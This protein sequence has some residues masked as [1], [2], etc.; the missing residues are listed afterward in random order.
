MDLFILLATVLIKGIG[1]LLFMA[2]PW[3]AWRKGFPVRALVL[4]TIA[5]SVVVLLW[6]P[7]SGAEGAAQMVGQMWWLSV[8]F[9]VC[10]P[11]GMWAHYR[12]EKQINN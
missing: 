10:A 7:F 5:V 8:I 3:F 12:R 6:G 1:T 4:L 2:M 9:M 11:L